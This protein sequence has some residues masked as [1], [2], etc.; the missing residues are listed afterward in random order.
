MKLLVLNPNTT[1]SMTDAV[2]AQALHHAPPGTEITGMTAQS[3]CTVIDSPETFAEGAK[4]ALQMLA[5]V[6][7]QTDAMLLA[8]FGDPG[9]E[10]L[11]RA[12]AIPVVGLAQAAVHAAALAG[13]PFAIVTAGTQWVAMLQ[14]RVHDFAAH[15]LLVGVYA[16]PV[17]GAQLRSDPAAFQHEVFQLSM[18]AADAGARSLILGGAAFA[19]LAF[20]IDDRLTLL[21]PVEMALRAMLCG[22]PEV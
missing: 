5:H 21:D 11:Q 15:Q 6:P 8:C 20:S 3:G 16:L 4:T 12:A 22:P 14:K 19:G 2:V 13:Q 9:L 1:A 7:P 18:L 17:N 10:V